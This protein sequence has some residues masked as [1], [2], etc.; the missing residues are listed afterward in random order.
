MKK[1]SRSD[2]K[3]FT[4]NS[5]NS[6]WKKTMSKG[7]NLSKFKLKM[8]AREKTLKIQTEENDEATKKLETNT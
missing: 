6:N 8:F 5:E 2:N 7:K 4:K 3:W 1:Q